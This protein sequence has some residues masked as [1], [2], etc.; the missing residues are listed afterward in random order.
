MNSKNNYPLAPNHMPRKLYKQADVMGVEGENYIP[1]QSLLAG[2]KGKIILTEEQLS[3]IRIL[4]KFGKSIKEL[5]HMF[6]VPEYEI[7]KYL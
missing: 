2:N 5:S 1:G 6:E 7:K 3:K 4:S